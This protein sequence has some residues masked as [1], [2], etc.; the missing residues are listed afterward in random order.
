V[1]FIFGSISLLFSGLRFL[2]ERLL[3]DPTESLRKYD[4][5]SYPYAFTFGVLCILS[6]YLLNAYLRPR[7]PNSVN[8]SGHPRQ[9]P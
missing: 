2:V 3:F 8:H 1:L 7:S 9:N 4:V 6:L 5:I